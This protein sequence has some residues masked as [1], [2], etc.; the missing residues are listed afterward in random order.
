MNLQE[1]LNLPFPLRPYQEEGFNFLISNDRALLGDDM[2]LG[3]TVQAIVALKKT[4]EERGFFRAL[5][6]VP[7]PLITN[8]LEELSIW[9]QNSSVQILKGDL[10]DRT[11]QLKDQKVLYFVVMSK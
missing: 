3:K 10:F 11:S 5:I 9:F 2:G 7:N 4:Y 1:E 8:W 6:V